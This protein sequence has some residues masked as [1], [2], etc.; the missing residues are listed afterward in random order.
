MIFIKILQF[1]Y[2][3]GRL[4]CSCRSRI[5]QLPPPV[6]KYQLLGW[7]PPL[8]P[9]AIRRAPG[10]S[11]ASIRWARKPSLHFTG[12]AYPLRAGFFSSPPR[13]FP[14]KPLLLSLLLCAAESDPQARR[15]SGRLFPR[16]AAP[17]K[18]G[19]CAV[20]HPGSSFSSHSQW[21]SFV[22]MRRWMLW[23]KIG[24]GNLAG[25]G[26]PFKGKEAKI[27]VLEKEC[28]GGER[29]VLVPCRLRLK[30]PVL[31]QESASRRW[32]GMLLY[33]K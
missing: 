12:E 33:L 31:M 1:L 4:T 22:R 18:V 14:F 28:A 8:V 2:V 15:I 3:T 24:R 6:W 10:S 21:Q 32:E 17:H 27:G 26:Q 20:Q 30:A 13:L 7:R 19:W 16:A 5:P 11:V 29:G 23:T 9:R 25:F